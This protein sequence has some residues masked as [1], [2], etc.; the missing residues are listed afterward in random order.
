MRTELICILDRSGSMESMAKE[1][2]GGFNGFLDDQKAIPDPAN[3]TVVLFDNEYKVLHNAIDI[4]DVSPMDELQY[5]PRGTTALLDA[6]GKTIGDVRERIN[7]QLA[8]IRKVKADA[9]APKVIVM[10]MTD[11]QENSSKEYSKAKVKEL[12]EGC[13]KD[14]WQFLFLSADMDGFAEAA[15]WG[16]DVNMRV[17]YAGTG[18][19]QMRGYNYTSNVIGKYRTGLT[20]TLCSDK[21]Y[22]GDKEENDKDNDSK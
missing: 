9:I 8:E 21:S 17:G 14:S 22:I 3:M 4:Q 5:Q 20:E 15:N 10:I 6:I 11:G 1:A 16:F 2:I 12:I 13:K 18:T 7:T 19:A